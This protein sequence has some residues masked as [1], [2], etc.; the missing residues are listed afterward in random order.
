[1]ALTKINVLVEN[2]PYCGGIEIHSTAVTETLGNINRIVVSRKKAG[3]TDW[4]VIHTIT[5]ETIDDLS[6]DLFD[7]LTLAGTTYSYNIDI[8]NNN[9]IIEMGMI[10]NVK[11]TF[12]GLFVGDFEHQYIAGTNF[13]TEYST[14]QSIEYVE[15]LSSKY[16][17]RVSNSAANYCTGTSSGLFLE[18]TDDKKSFKPDTYHAHTDKVLDFLRDG[19]TKI[20]KTHDGHG[21]C[22]SID[23]QPSKVYSDYIGMNAIQFAWTEIDDF[24]TSGLGTVGD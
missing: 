19:G 13:K 7:I 1:M 2:N 14:N 8:K 4:N 9:S 6:F 16:P 10:E 11:C 23:A 20:L 24:P 18:L 15:T 12:E 21:W 3:M 5:V 22:V 17:F